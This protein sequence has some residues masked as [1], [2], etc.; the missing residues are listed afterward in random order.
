MCFPWFSLFFQWK[1]NDFLIL[2]WCLH[3]PAWKNICFYIRSSDSTIIACFFI[4]KSCCYMNPCDF[5]MIAWFGVG[6]KRHGQSAGCRNWCQAQGIR[7][8]GQG[9]WSQK[10]SHMLMITLKSVEI[11][12]FHGWLLGLQSNYVSLGQPQ[13]TKSVSRHE[14]CCLPSKT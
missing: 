6:N 11:L 14:F 7:W 8:C 1:H 3:V 9:F 5:P 4:E 13:V 2:L 12:W 10:H